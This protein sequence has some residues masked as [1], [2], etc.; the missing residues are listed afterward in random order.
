LGQSPAVLLGRSS[1]SAGLPQSITGPA[2]NPALPAR[3]P[4]GYCKVMPSTYPDIVRCPPGLIAEAA[5]LVLGDLA[6]ALRAE[7]A[8]E[9]FDRFRPPADE[10]IYVAL[11]DGA[12]CGVA[13]GQR[14]PG[15]TAILWPPRF[16]PGGDFAAVEPLIEAVVDELDADGVGMTQVLLAED[17][18]ATVPTIQSAGFSHL[19][20]LLYLSCE[21]TSFP[22]ACPPAGPLEFEPFDPSQ[23]GRLIEVVE[24]TYEGTQD[25]VALGGARQME[26]VIDGYQAAGQFH[27]S[28]WLLVRAEGEDAGV[29]L[30]ADHP[31]LG[32]LELL[33]M[34]LIPQFRGRGWGALI[35]RYAQW[36][37]RCAKAERIVLAVDAANAP[38]L[39]MYQ[40]TGFIAWD[41]RTVFVR[42]PERHEQT[43]VNL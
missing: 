1:T 22:V 18:T 16:V 17:D 5:A 3:S 4:I 15:N 14:Q 33:Y 36:L 41:Q 24:R 27:A 37:A 21:A 11:S 29:L 43:A 38:A 20:D 35:T 2:E 8:P 10:A 40:D 6:P 9:L 26:D 34:G 7:I 13:W 42:F 12:V 25:C 23:R 30:L 28:H 32:H 39:A 19:A 31:A